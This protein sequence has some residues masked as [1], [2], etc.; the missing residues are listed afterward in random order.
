MAPQVVGELRD[1]RVALGDRSLERLGDDRVEVARERAREPIRRR[2]SRLETR[3]LGIAIVFRVGVC[4]AGSAA[5]R[6]TRVAHPRRRAGGDGAHELGW[7]SV[8]ARHRMFAGQEL[9]EQHAE[10]VDIG[11]GGDRATF[12]LLRRGVLRGQRPRRR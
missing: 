6:R 5:L 9:I 12:E 4:G 3:R 1:G 2:R 7:R 11:G 8:G 10:G